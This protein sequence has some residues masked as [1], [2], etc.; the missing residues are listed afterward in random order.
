[1]TI[2]LPFF[3]TPLGGNVSSSIHLEIANYLRVI[4]DLD[5]HKFLPYLHQTGLRPPFDLIRNPLGGVGVGFQSRV[6]LDE[7]VRDVVGRRGGRVPLLVVRAHPVRTVQTYTFEGGVLV[8]DG[9][10]L[11]KAIGNEMTDEGRTC[12][13]SGGGH[14]QPRFQEGKVVDGEAAEVVEV[15]RGLGG[16]GMLA[17]P[18]DTHGQ[19][20]L[21]AH[22]EEQGR[23]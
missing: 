23:H 14:H 3:V 2:S 1:M 11:R 13:T 22:L 9:A 12:Q 7:L 10:P 17:R 20:A 15:V 21:I 8:K 16:G 5:P 18:G 19:L 4:R 6:G